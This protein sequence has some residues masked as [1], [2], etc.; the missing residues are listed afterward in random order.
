MFISLNERE[1]NCFKKGWSTSQK[2]RNWHRKTAFAKIECFLNQR[3][4]PTSIPRKFQFS[5]PLTVVI[6]NVHDNFPLITPFFWSCCAFLLEK[7]LLLFLRNKA[8]LRKLLGVLGQQTNP[9]S[10]CI[11]QECCWVRRSPKPR[12]KSPEE[13]VWLS[14]FLH[15]LGSPYRKSLSCA[16]NQKPEGAR[17]L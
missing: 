16:A 12:Y 14:T 4:P 7:H 13:S 11:W 17:T 15:S 8:L 6:S 2:Y 3:F 1:I 9:D 10:A 5:V